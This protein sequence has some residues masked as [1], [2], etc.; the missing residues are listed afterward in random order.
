[1]IFLVKNL[2]VLLCIIFVLLISY[3]QAQSSGIKFVRNEDKSVTFSYFKKNPGSLFVVL[4]LTEL[5]NTI[6]GVVKT[7]VYGHG[8]KLVTLH[9]TYKDKQ[10][11]FSYS[12]KTI[13]TFLGDID[14]KPDLEFKYILPLRNVRNVGVIDLD[15]KFKKEPNPTY[16]GRVWYEFEA[17]P[18]DTV[19]AVRKGIVVSLKNGKRLINL[20]KPRA[21]KE[22]STIVVEHEDG[23]LSRYKFLMLDELKVGVGDVVYPS[24]PLGVV[25]VMGKEQNGEL[26]LSISHLSEDVKDMDFFNN[27][28]EN[29][30]VIYDLYNYLNVFFYVNSDEVL[31]LEKGKSYI[32]FCNEA[33]IEFEMSNKE[34]KHRRKSLK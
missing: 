28:Y 18:N 3:V 1:M 25:S 26:H 5:E 13:K 22:L 20:K 14:A 21:R 10:I 24:S 15:Y 9:P 2:K 8:G 11:G 30:N 16:T 7:S 12:P 32:A 31:K 6:Q 34:K 29:Q 33:I 27:K 19:F 23:T 17:K 4:K